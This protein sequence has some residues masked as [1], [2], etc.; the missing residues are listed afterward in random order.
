MPQNLLDDLK[1]VLEKNENLLVDGQ[2]NKA[3][4]EQKALA[5]DAD[6]L[7]LIL[8]SESLKKHFFEDIEG[9]LVFDKVKFQQFISNK[10]FLPD[11]YTSFKINIGL[12]SNLNYLS[13]S[14][15]VVLAWPHKDCVLQGGQDK[16]DAKREEIFWNETLA[17]DDIDRLLA[18]KVF[19]NWKK[20]DKDGEKKVKAPSLK[21]NYL[22]KGNNLLAL[23]SLAEVYRGKVKLIYIDPPYN[24]G[25]DA[26]I[27][28]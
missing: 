17:P 27:F 22:I 18:P 7:N 2:L 21:D 11:S 4:I 6:F 20:Y 24:T 12:T 13:N 14:G 15:E 28:S 19:T 9:A 26:N 25:G 5:L 16:E 1:T 10:S 23:Q 3:L 8:G